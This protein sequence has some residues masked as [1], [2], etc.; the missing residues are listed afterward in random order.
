MSVMLSIPARPCVDE[1]R[2]TFPED[3]IYRGVE[4]GVFKGDHAESLLKGL[5]IDTSQGE[6]W[7]VDCWGKFTPEA[8]AYRGGGVMYRENNDEGWEAIYQKVKT[9][10]A[11]YSNVHLVRSPSVDA[12]K[13][14]E[15]PLD[16]VY[17]DAGHTSEAVTADINAWLPKVRIGGWVMGDDYNRKENQQLSVKPAVDKFA[18][19]HGYT[20]V[21]RSE[22][23][24]H[25]ENATQWWFIKTHEIEDLG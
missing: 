23:P 11:P 19:D 17:I 4:I 10:F 18:L 21:S 1:M 3:Y 14:I 20:L 12:A 24:Q 16:F 2:R 5:C 6:L 22:L 15:T 8:E 9:R 7:L 13:L 25:R